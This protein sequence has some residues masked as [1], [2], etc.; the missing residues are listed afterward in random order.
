MD[1]GDY[2]MVETKPVSRKFV[3]LARQKDPMLGH[4]LQAFRRAGLVPQAIIVDE[5]E[6]SLKDLTIFRERTGGK[7]QPLELSDILFS[8]ASVH[9]VTDHNNSDTLDLVSRFAPDFILNA[10]TPR[11][12]KQSLLDASPIGVIN[13]HPGL[14]P[15]F[16]GC[17][18]VEWAVLLDEPLGLSVHRM[19][20]GIDEGP[21]LMTRIMPLKIYNDYVSLRVAT[22][23][24]ACELMAEAASGLC[25]LRLNAEDFKP[26]EAD[27]GRYFKPISNEQLVEVRAKISETF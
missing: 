2:L 23:F 27:A 5:K 12:L 16:R 6:L 1:D 24:G 13:V 10:G 8:G 4:Y 22:Y 11:I 25:S 18:C 14:L 20:L 9:S 15:M 26:Q 7:I 3:V 17:S 21:V 19:T